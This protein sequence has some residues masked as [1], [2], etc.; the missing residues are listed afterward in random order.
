[1]VRRRAEGAGGT[2]GAGAIFGP[3]GSPRPGPR[4]ALDRLRG[5][6]ARDLLQALA[7]PAGVGLFRLRQGFKPFREFR[8]PFRTSGLC[9]A[10]IHLGVFVGLP[11]DGR[12]EIF[13]GAADGR[14]RNWIADFFE[15]IKVTECMP[16]LG[17]GSVAE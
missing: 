10:R 8:Q 1:M 11:F 4:R 16:G 14:A 6:L 3:T 7:E 15:K 12:F 5:L 2:A 17:L 13:F 9:E